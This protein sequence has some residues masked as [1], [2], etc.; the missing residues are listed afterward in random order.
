MV[1]DTSTNSK[2]VGDEN[3]EGEMGI[4]REDFK[5]GETESPHK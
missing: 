4:A 5:R 1:I 3:V 2:Y